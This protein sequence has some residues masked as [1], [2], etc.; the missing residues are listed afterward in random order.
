LGILQTSGKKFILTTESDCGIILLFCFSASLAGLVAPYMIVAV[1]L[2]LMVAILAKFVCNMIES[3]QQRNK[4]M[5]MRTKIFPAIGASA[6]EV[7]RT[8][9]NSVAATAVL[10]KRQNN[11][12]WM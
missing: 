2:G 4:V 10:T 7:V 6:L 8:M 12:W 11:F 5:P 9:G 1:P 3:K